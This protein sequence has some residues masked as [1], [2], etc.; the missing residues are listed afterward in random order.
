MS[1]HICTHARTH[2][3]FGALDDALMGL[4]ELGF[5]EAAVH[6]HMPPE[7]AC[8]TWPQ[9]HTLTSL[10]TMACRDATLPVAKLLF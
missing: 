6:L 2:T 1:T 9:F 7:S 3:F 4:I 8:T 10:N 5:T